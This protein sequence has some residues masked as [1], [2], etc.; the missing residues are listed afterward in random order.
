MYL[1]ASLIFIVSALIGGF[2]LSL[3][4]FIRSRKKQVS[5]QKISKGPDVT[6]PKNN[7]E[8]SYQNSASRDYALPNND[9]SSTYCVIDDRLI[10]Q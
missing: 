2:F 1:P 7:D 9:K 6:K 4:F 10:D 8:P 3:L 5:Y